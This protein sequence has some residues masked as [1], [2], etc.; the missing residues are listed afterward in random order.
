VHIAALYQGILPLLLYFTWVLVGL[1]AP[2]DMRGE[3]FLR[4]IAEEMINQGLCVA[5]AEKVTEFSATE[6]V[7]RKHSME[8]VRETRVI[9]VFGDT[10]DFLITVYLS[11]YYAF[12]VMS[13][14]QLLIGISHYPLNK[15]LFIDILVED[16]Y[17]H[18][19]WMKLW[20]LRI[21]SEVFNLENI[22]M[23]SLS[24]KCG[25]SI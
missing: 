20:D 22:L 18:F 7:N 21:F 15:I 23:I 16:Y 5:F 13:G 6:S 1:V 8:R 25:P 2:D 3:I 17:F 9:V 24:R 19:A 4:G 14:S 11:I 12:L 10:H